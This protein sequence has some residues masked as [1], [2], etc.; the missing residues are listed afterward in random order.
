MD[1]RPALDQAVS[2]SAGPRAAT[3]GQRSAGNLRHRPRPRGPRASVRSC[4]ALTRPKAGAGKETAAPL[5]CASGGGIERV[6]R[7]ARARLGS[8]R[9]RRRL[10]P[11]SPGGPQRPP[12]SASPGA[13]RAH[14]ALGLSL[15]RAA[16]QGTGRRRGGCPGA[17]CVPRL[18]AG[19]AQG[20]GRDSA[21]QTFLRCSVRRKHPAQ[22]LTE[23]AGGSVA[24]GDR[25]GPALGSALEFLG[26]L[27]AP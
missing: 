4:V 6:S 13:P 19:A 25:P 21:A 17:G 10:G 15:P 16:R 8:G 26:T 7:A 20:G 12:P 2:A 9:Q 5:V 1:R 14:P 22:R 23:S 3:R 24:R 27:K 11:A 18:L